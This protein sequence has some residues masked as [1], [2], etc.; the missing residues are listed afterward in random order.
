L[1]LMPKDAL[2]AR[3]QILG[4]KPEAVVPF[5]LLRTW[6]VDPDEGTALLALQ[7]VLHPKAENTSAQVRPSGWFI[8]NKN[9]EEG[10][11]LTYIVEHDLVRSR[12][13]CL[14]M[15][16]KDIVEM[17]AGIATVWFDRLG[18]LLDHATAI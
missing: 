18:A 12:E 5:C 14:G 6:Q 7:S 4:V 9:L 17:M 1:A 13:V 3:E 16:D 8:N 2:Q 15:S 11:Q 10:V